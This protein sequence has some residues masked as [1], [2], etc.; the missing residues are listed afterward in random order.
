[1]SGTDIP[2]PDYFTGRLTQTDV[3]EVIKDRCGALYPPALERGH[4][5]S[6]I[7]GGNSEVLAWSQDLP[8][9]LPTIGGPRLDPTVVAIFAAEVGTLPMAL[10]QIQI[11]EQP[12]VGEVDLRT[13]SGW[14]TV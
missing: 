6:D 2:G 1:M 12:V 5:L 14:K 7:A 9:Q 4:T 11:V 3:V 8:F 10:S 13:M